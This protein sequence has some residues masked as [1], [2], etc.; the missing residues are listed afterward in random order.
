MA[1]HK[2]FEPG[3]PPSRPGPLFARADRRAAGSRRVVLAGPVWP[4]RP[5]SGY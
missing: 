1:E 4:C 3:R 2:T 5:A